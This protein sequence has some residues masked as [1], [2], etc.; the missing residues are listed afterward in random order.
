MATGEGSGFAATRGSETDDEGRDFAEHGRL[1]RHLKDDAIGS[2]ETVQRALCVVAALGL[3]VLAQVNFGVEV[4]SPWRAQ[5]SPLGFLFALGLTT[6]ACT[7]RSKRALDWVMLAVLVVAIALTATEATGILLARHGFGEDDGAFVQYGTRLLLRGVNPFTHSMAPGLQLYGASPTPTALTNGT[8]SSAYDYP[9]LPLLLNVPFYWL[10]NGVESVTVAAVFFQCVAGFVLYSMLPRGLRA[11]AVITVFEIPLLF[12]FEV[13]GSF[14]PMFLPFALVAIWNWTE[15]GRT[16]RL[17]RGDLT[18]AVCLGL[19]CAI[20]QIVWL[21]A[22]FLVLG[23]WRAGSRRLGNAGSARVALRFALAVLAAFGIVNLPFIIWSADA[24]WRDVIAPFTQ[25]SIP[26]GEGLVDLTVLL[27]LGGGNLGWYSDAALA[28]LAGLLVA[29]VVWFRGLWRAGIVLAGLMFFVSTRPLDGYW[30][31]VAPLWLAAVVVPGPAPRPVPIAWSLSRL[32]SLRIGL[33]AAVFAPTLA[34]IGLA[35]SASAP[36]VLRVESISVEVQ[37]QD[38]WEAVVRATNLTGHPVRPHFA[39]DSGGQLSSY[40]TIDSGPA[41]L[42]GGHSALYILSS[43][44]LGTNPGLDT[45]FVISAV[46]AA[47]D[48]LSTSPAYL[49]RKF[50]IVLTPSAV[51]GPVPVGRSIIF[52]A[53][54]ENA[55]G[56]PVRASGIRVAMWAVVLAQSG[57]QHAEASINGFPNTKH[58][59]FARTTSNGSATFR[60]LDLAPEGTHSPPVYL[61]SWIHP[62]NSYNYGY[63]GPVEVKWSSPA[64]R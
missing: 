29:Y 52:H 17:S 43:P 7:V 8:I 63:S 36:L 51:N 39:D 4:S 62:K 21:M 34:F 20:E 50:H 28:L 40:W 24:W 31:E 56:V 45:P 6:A 59:V 64:T 30:L 14:Y 42:R 27:H 53:Q 10:T 15:I 57:S 9:S 26:Y 32:T 13:S 11:L 19:A 2:P 1:P 37:R 54:I 25:H 35:L 22:L 41:T 61:L 12:G 60:V 23:I 49:A 47:P 18:R 48:A 58:V 46:S 33:T 3:L 38:I 44:N 55:S 5:I 16:G